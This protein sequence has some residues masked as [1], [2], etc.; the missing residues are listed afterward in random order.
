MNSC[1]KFY[2]RRC[3]CHP[4]RPGCRR[5]VFWIE[6]SVQVPHQG[7]GTEVLLARGVMTAV[8][9]TRPRGRARA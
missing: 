2:Y 1:P 8:S 9:T 3:W 7:G 5:S 6:R 4:G